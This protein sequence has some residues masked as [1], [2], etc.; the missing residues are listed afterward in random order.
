MKV[1]LIDDDRDLVTALLHALERAGYTAW[2]ARSAA[3]A[4]D[5]LAAERPDLVVLAVPM[6]SA[7]ALDLLGRIRRRDQ[8]VVIML[9]GRGD[10]DARVQGLDMGAD[11]Y[12]AKP[13]SPRE[14]VARIRAITRR[15]ESY[16]VPSGHLLTVGDLTMNL[17]A[18]TVWQAGEGLAL[19]PTE[20]RLL[21]YLMTRAGE[22]V[23]FDTLMRR[24]WG[25]DD[26][27]ETDVVRTTVYRLRRKL[28]SEP[29][30]SHVIR[31]IPGIGYLLIDSVGS[32]PA[33]RLMVR[34]CDRLGRR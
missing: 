21:E 18:R 12:V 9:T 28:R 24:I 19:T 15:H 6:R 32:P 5:L 16:I 11:D 10:E 33:W 31:S 8:S 13:F 7:M 3:A 25:C 29:A 27:S 4:L 26:P 2:S 20:Y 22:A 1:L 17:T 23:T 34:R 30:G 14:L